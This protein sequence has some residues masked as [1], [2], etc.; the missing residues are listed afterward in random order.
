MAHHARLLA[1]PRRKRAQNSFINVPRSREKGKGPGKIPAENRRWDRLI[2]RYPRRFHWLSSLWSAEKRS[3][4]NFWKSLSVYFV[5]N[6]CRSLS[7]GAARL[8]CPAPVPEAFPAP[9]ARSPPPPKSGFS[10]RR[11][12]SK[13]RRSI[14]REMERRWAAARPVRPL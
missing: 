7:G 5:I 1:Q 14:S 13:N 8:T 12:G 4:C 11:P 3:L 6:F 9:A 2:F 10:P